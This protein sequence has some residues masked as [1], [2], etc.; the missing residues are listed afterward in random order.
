MT[1]TIVHEFPIT[2]EIRGL[3]FSRV[4][5]M[6]KTL[7]V[8]NAKMDPIQCQYYK[9]DSIKT[10]KMLRKALVDT[11]EFDIKVIDKFI[12]LLSQI[13]VQLVE[14]QDQAA[15]S[16]SDAEK[17]Q[18]DSIIQEVKELR[19]ANAGITAE[20][21]ISGLTKRYEELRKVVLDN[22]PEL[23]AGLEFE[24]SIMR[25]LNIDKCTLPF[26]GIILGR[27]ASCKTQ[28]ISLL[29]K[30]PY[31]YYTDN[32]THAS[33]FIFSPF[34]SNSRIRSLGERLTLV[35]RAMS[36]LGIKL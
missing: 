13:W 32:F 31:S 6:G 29:K 4:C 36:S 30:W 25:I 14:A 1:G 22:I 24:L 7:L 8:Y 16:V 12:V 27:P 3:G 19:V 10:I 28:I 15:K 5:T 34:N 35:S 26:I 18:K 9:D 17:K 21:W 20:D 11:H 23:W 2:D 33:S